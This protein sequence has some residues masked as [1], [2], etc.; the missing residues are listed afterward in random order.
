MIPS[1]DLRIMPCRMRPHGRQ[2][3]TGQQPVQLLHGQF[4]DRGFL[5]PAETIRFQPLEHQPETGAVPSSSLIRSRRRLLNTKTAGAKDRVSGLLDQQRQPF[6]GLA[7]IDGFAVQ[8]DLQARFEAEHSSS[9][10]RQ[11][12]KG[13]ETV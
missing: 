11:L 10:A 5:R 4:D 12:N 1:P 13:R 8:V 3:N 7:A 9:P 6:D 2:V